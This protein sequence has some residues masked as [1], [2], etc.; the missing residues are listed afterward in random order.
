MSP[1]ELEVCRDVPSHDRRTVGGELV[2]STKELTVTTGWGQ[3]RKPRFVGFA[4]GDGGL[5]AQHVG[6][7]IQ[8]GV[9]KQMV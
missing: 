6:P 4:E 5:L 7:S 8:N 1:L 3:G 2:P 9:L